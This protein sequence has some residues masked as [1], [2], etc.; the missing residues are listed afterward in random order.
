M[1]P[2]P[3]R[4]AICAALL[5]A[6]KGRT[7]TVDRDDTAPHPASGSE[8]APQPQARAEF[9]PQPQAR[10]EPLPSVHA[11]ETTLPTGCKR[12]DKEFT[13]PSTPPEH[14]VWVEV[15]CEAGDKDTMIELS[16]PRE[17]Y[18]DV[19]MYIDRRK[20]EDWKDRAVTVRS[21]KLSDGWLGVFTFEDGK[22]LVDAFRTIG[23]T[24]VGCGATLVPP[25]EVERVVAVCKSAH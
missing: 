13:K 2:G 6:C 21:E 23:G 15:R 10:T 19:E 25:S 11:L 7:S 8:S 1:L 3:I 5:V 16:V 17:A 14:L 22:A 20:R 12:K 9:T 24:T 4:L 18:Q